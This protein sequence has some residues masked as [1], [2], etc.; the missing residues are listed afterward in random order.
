MK[1]IFSLYFA[2][3]FLSNFSSVVGSDRSDCWLI[4]V[5]SKQLAIGEQWTTV[6]YSKLNYRPIAQI[7][8]SINLVGS[9][10]RVSGVSMSSSH[11][12]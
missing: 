12:C 11:A 8:L 10:E 5:L 2:I 3:N 9:I 1:A 6:A 7:V 4:C